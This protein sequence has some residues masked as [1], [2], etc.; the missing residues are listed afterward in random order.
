MFQSL[1]FKGLRKYL[2]AIFELTDNWVDKIRLQVLIV[3]S[4]KQ[5]RLQVLIVAEEW[6]Q[7]AGRFLRSLPQ[8]YSLFTV[9]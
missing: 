5:I 6:K 1:K 3:A 7:K 9:C 2:D 8:G 4:F